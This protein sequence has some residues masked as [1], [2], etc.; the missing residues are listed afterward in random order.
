[1][2]RA[3]GVEGKVW[4]GMFAILP[5]KLTAGGARRRYQN[6]SLQPSA[7][8]DLALVV[9]VA[10]HAEEVRQQLLKVARTATGTAFSV[11]SVEVFDAYQGTGLPEGKKS[12]AFA[13]SFR[14]AERTLTDDEVNAVFAKIQLAIVADG[15]LSVRA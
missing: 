15:S 11:E 7:L 10:R 3:A 14:S 6:F 1:M 9:D 13:L 4:A 2:V 12:V 8:R 5:E